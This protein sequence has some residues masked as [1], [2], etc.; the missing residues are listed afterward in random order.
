MGPSARQ[1]ER[2][3]QSTHLEICLPCE[4]LKWG[5]HSRVLNSPEEHL[6]KMYYL[7]A[8]GNNLCYQRE[9]ATI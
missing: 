3:P 4:E 2:L 1:Y 5:D 9:N 7:N 8:K 6:Q